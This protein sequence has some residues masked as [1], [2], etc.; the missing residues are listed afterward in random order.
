MAQAS[1]QISKEFHQLYTKS[2]L[3]EVYTAAYKFHKRETEKFRALLT[4]LSGSIVLELD[5]PEVNVTYDL[6]EEMKRLL[7]KRQDE[8]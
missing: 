6:T 4:E 5:K 1:Q 2:Q 8:M 3:I 7:L